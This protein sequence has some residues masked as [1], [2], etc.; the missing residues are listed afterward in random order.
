[1]S[2]FLS[3]ISRFAC[4]VYARFHANAALCAVANAGGGLV[5]QLRILQQRLVREKYLRALGAG[6]GRETRAQR[7]ELRRARR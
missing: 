7:F 5:E 6:I 4:A 2:S 1:M 3:V